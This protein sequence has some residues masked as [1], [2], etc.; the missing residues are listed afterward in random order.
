MPDAL[1]SRW[2]LHSH[3]QHYSRGSPV[4]SPMDLRPPT[5][6][7][8][9]P[10]TPVPSSSQGHAHSNPI[11]S[12]AV[13][14]GSVFALP[15][16]M[17]FAVVTMDTVAIYDTQQAG[18]VCLLTKLHYDEFTD[19]TW[20]VSAPLFIASVETDHLSTLCQLGHQTGNA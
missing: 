2:I 18:P 20:C 10:P 6:A 8:S 17:L 15:Y 11:T 14:T 3:H 1:F 9:K 5:P 7:A 13:H 4:L 12:S 19:M 16:R